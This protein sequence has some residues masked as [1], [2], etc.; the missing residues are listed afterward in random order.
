MAHK[1]LFGELIAAHEGLAEELK[2]VDV[3]ADLTLLLNHAGVSRADLARK[4]GWSRARVSQVL[5]GQENITVQTIA[6]VA[7]ALGYTFDTVFRKADVSAAS[8]PWSQR[9]ALT[10]EMK[11]EPDVQSWMS[12]KTMKPVQERFH[13]AYEVQHMGLTFDASNHEFVVLEEACAA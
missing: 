11:D 2:A 5:S 10:L 4:L 3:A 1:P 9:T 8:Q 13:G 12:R 6:A 7:G